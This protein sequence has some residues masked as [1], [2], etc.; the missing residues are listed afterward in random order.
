[1]HTVLLGKQMIGRV[2]G[3]YFVVLVDIV[4]ASLAD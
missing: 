3:I 2:T 4:W 1:M